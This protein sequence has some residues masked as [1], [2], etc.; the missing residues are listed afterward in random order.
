MKFQNLDAF[1][2]DVKRKVLLGIEKDVV[3]IFKGVVLEATVNL[4]SGDGRYAG[5]P[6]WS[7]NAAANWW[8]T[9]NSP[10]TAFVPYFNNPK[11]PGP[12]SEYNGNANQREAAVAIS[13]MRVRQFLQQLPKSASRSMT[14]YITNTATYLREYQPYGEGATFRL[15]NLYP[16][17]AMRAAMALNAEVANASTSRLEGWKA[18]FK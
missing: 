3:P 14:V 11:W 15:E 16:L 9:V 6:E 18:G 2:A 8:P 5:T 12:P 4:V 17:S 7:G 13:V 1:M 10:A